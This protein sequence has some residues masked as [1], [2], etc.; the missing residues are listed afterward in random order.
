MSLKLIKGIGTIVWG[1]SNVL[2]APAGA[3]VE[4]IS[5]TP[6]NGE[7]VEIDDNDGITA[8]EVI[9][10]DGFNGKIS[11][12]YDANKAWPIEG[13]NA[14]LAIPFNGAN[15]NTIPFGESSVNGAT[16]AN[17]VVTYTVLIA[18]V[19]GVNYAKKKE[20]VVEF[21]VTYRPNVAV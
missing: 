4:S 2:N 5:L 15:T 18:S 12:M 6:K 3:I 9:L 14:S 16:Y 19:G 21:N 11:V 8:V 10:R 20:G 7:P 1:T 13:A 17:G